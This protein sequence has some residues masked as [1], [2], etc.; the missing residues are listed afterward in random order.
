MSKF[1]RLNRYPD[2]GISKDGEVF[3][4][5]NNIV[6]KPIDNGRGYL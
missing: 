6:L 2:Y 5:K 4:F 3:S 1:V